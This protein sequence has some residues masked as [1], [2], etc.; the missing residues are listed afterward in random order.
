MPRTTTAGMYLS[1]AV[2]TTAGERPTTG[3]TIIPEVKSMPDTNPAPSSVD[4]TT[5]METEYV[6][7]EPALKDLG[8]S[9]DYSVNFTDEL[10][11]IVDQL[12]DAQ[13]AAEAEGKAVWFCEAHRKIKNAM[14]YTG[15]MARI[16]FG[17]SSVGNMLET[18]LHITPTG[19]PKRAE[20][21]PG[22]TPGTATENASV[23][24][25]AARQSTKKATEVDV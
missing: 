1:Y 14:Y 2:E 4:S 21:A 17:E 25:F 19:A 10:E 23:Q 6:T 18:S 15:K 20:K 8:D 9:L 7:K 22:T 3:Y 13:E 11:E 5:L 24:T 12:V 16:N